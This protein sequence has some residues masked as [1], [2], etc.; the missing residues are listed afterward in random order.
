MN[1]QYDATQR[2]LRQFKLAKQDAQ[3]L[4]MYALSY[5]RSFEVMEQVAEEIYCTVRS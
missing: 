3:T 2:L 4:P 5:P 1:I